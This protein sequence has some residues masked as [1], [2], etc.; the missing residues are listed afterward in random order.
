MCVC[1]C[2]ENS[3]TFTIHSYHVIMFLT[4]LACIYAACVGYLVSVSSV[5]VF[6]IKSIYVPLPL[7]TKQGDTFCVLSVY[8]WERGRGRGFLSIGDIFLLGSCRRGFICARAQVWILMQ[9]TIIRGYIFCLS[10]QHTDTHTHR[11]TSNI[12]YEYI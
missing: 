5:E 6:V 4:T 7:T 10:F 1:V 11:G 12:M 9:S 2:V 3:I 8:V